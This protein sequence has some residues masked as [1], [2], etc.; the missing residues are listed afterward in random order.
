MNPILESFNTPFETAPFDKIK[1]EHYLPALREGIVRAKNEIAKIKNN[2]DQPNFENVIVALEESSLYV[3][4]CAEIFFNL[5]S[6]ES[7]D[8]LQ[9]IAKDF[10]PLLTEYGNDVLLDKELFLRVK[11]VHDNKDKLNLTVEQKT[12]LDKT[13]KGFAR[14]G[15]LLD[16]GQKSKL[17]EIDN[18]LSKLTLE[19]GDHVLFETNSYL[20]VVQ[21]VKE[22]EGLPDNVIEQA[23]MTAKEKG[24]EGYAL[25]LSMPCYVAVMTYAKNRA[26]REELYRAYGSKAYK[27]DANDNQKVIKELVR[28]R[29]ERANLLG[30]KNHSEYVLEERMAGKPETVFSF[31]EDILVKAKPVALQELDELKAFA[32]KEDQIQDFKPWDGTYYSEKLKKVKFNVNDEMLKPYFKLENVI[33]G[34]FEV[35]KRL[36]GISFIERKDIPLY[37][38]E[39]RT[40]E[41]LDEK[42]E[43]LSVFY[44]DFFPRAG[45]RNGAWMTSYRSQRKSGGKDIRPHISIVCNFTKPTATKPS[46]LTFD[47]VNTLFH[48]FGH[49]LHGMLSNCNYQSISG[50]NVY[51]D[52]VELPSQIM[53]NWTHEKECLDI[54]ARHYETGEKIPAE[55]IQRIKDSSNFHE[56]RFTLRQLSL[57]LLDMA[58]HTANP[59][60]IQNVS[61]FERVAV[62]R[63]QILPYDPE[64]NTSCSFSHIFAGGYSSGYYSYKWAEVLDADAF[65]LFVEKGIFNPEIAKSFAQ[66]ILS[67]GGSEHPLELF[68]KFRGREP[69]VDALLKR[70]GLIK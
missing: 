63:T 50:T 54:F 62:E 45:K 18:A 13:Y 53:E 25:T 20:K 12:L 8:E 69:K 1:N 11:A 39:V 58:W 5:H 68:K 37:H 33:E 46:L 36:Y 16:E 35:A 30:Y 56:G 66:N 43:H 23:Q 26:L 65:D 9:K 41:V 28:L 15:A 27:N 24:K 31:L 67:R 34:V 10:S 49:A 32:K 60:N 40:Y 70:A 2:K 44:A 29:K 21:D 4:R 7:N 19:F 22:L 48:E 59:E 14:N 61:D 3:D 51:W 52:F 47:E 57:G 42:G 6:A 55:L 17:R 64:I 38:S